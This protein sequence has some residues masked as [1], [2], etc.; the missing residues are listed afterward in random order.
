MLNFSVYNKYYKINPNRGQYLWNQI[1]QK[2]ISH[3]SQTIYQLHH[4]RAT[5]PHPE[6]MSNQTHHGHTDIQMSRHNLCS[7]NHTRYVLLYHALTPDCKRA[8]NTNIAFL[9]E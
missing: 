7:S 4:T 8:E 1:Q 2:S 6:I 3:K 5:L 9:Y